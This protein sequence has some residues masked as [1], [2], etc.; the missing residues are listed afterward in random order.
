MDARTGSLGR[1]NAVAAAETLWLMGQ[2]TL[3]DLL[4]FVREEVVDGADISRIDLAAQWRAGNDIYHELER[5]EAGEADKV[6][7]RA[8]DRPGKARAARLEADPRHRGAFDVVPTRVAMVELDRLIVSRTDIAADP[9]H[10]LPDDLFDFCL[11]LEPPRPVLRIVRVEDGRFLFACSGEE[12]RAGDVALLDEA[13]A[14]HLPAMG[15]PAIGGVAVPVALASPLMSAIHSD[16][17]L[18]LTN[19]HKRALA[20]RAAGIAFAPC[21]IHQVTRTDELA[22]V[23]RDQVVE[24]PEFYFRAKRPPLLRDFLD[25]RLVRRFAARPRE[26]IVEIELKVRSGPAIDC[27]GSLT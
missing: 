11:P 10:A 20:L 21:L 19:G 3:D 15:A 26:T 1:N 5:D 25:P 4:G 9:L 2:P 17:R 24:R 13:A 8:L 14:G 23:A 18:V 16:N 12:L 6:R 7:I 27:E 22:L